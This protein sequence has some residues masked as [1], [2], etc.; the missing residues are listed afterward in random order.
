MT[1]GKIYEGSKFQKFASE[2]DKIRLAIN[3]QNRRF[4]YEI[5]SLL[6]CFCL[7]FIQRKN[8]YNLNKINGLEAP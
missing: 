2:S 1:P 8:A 4:F 7:Q 3:F 6:F 5:R